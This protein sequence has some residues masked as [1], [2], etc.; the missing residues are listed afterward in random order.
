[1]I[2]RTMTKA[3]DILDSPGFRQAV[4]AVQMRAEKQT[5][6][7]HLVEVFVKTDLF[8]R[9]QSPD[10]QLILGRRGTG[11]THLLRVY[12]QD[13]VQHGVLVKY[14]DCTTLG[15]GHS[16]NNP[17]PDERALAYFSVFLNQV[18]TDLIDETI[19][20]ELLTPEWAN[21]LGDKLGY[22]LL[23]S[24]TATGCNYRQVSDTLRAVLQ[25]MRI[26][27]LCLVLDEWA[28]IPFDVQP[29]FAE[30]VKRAI[31]SVPEITVKILAV[32]VID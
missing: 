13:A 1:M 19:A 32:N 14:T 22:G 3:T 24:I 5:E 26:S 15:T 6:W 29:F 28:Q 25:A 20:S 4:G 8:E 17:Q 30:H 31:L 9:V 10:S 7:K 21:S 23:P 2:Y 11:K 12:Q 16:S 27:R 18:G